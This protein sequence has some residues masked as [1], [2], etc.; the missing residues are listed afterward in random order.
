VTKKLKSAIIRRQEHAQKLFARLNKKQPLA[1][2][3][4]VQSHSKNEAA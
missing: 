2:Q 3:L 1:V 4:A